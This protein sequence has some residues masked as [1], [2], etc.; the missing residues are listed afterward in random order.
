MKIA[1]IVYENELVNHTNV[2][3]INYHKKPID[4]D[5][6]D[7]NLP[8]LYVGWSFMKKCSLNNPIIQNANI[9]H[10]KII[11]NELYWEF[12]FIESKSSHVTGIES[13]VDLV[14]RFYFTP[15]YSYINLDPVFFQINNLEDLLDV[16][17]KNI[18][19]VYLFKKDMLY[20]LV[21]NKITGIDLKMY[22]FFKFNIDD[23]ISGLHKRTDFFHDDY[24]GEI[25]KSF[26]KK[27]PNFT[28][29]KRYVVTMV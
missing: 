10:K 5:D 19:K 16:V 21:D 27:L 1:N 17:A 6:L 22:D 26:Y 14:P 3:Y 11:G 29:L 25:Y 13:F 2:D 4:Y 7:K 15:K 20:L 12:D 23:I 9:L 28:L 24:E 8:T 18:N